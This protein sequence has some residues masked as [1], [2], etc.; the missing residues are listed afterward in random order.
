M[1][2]LGVATR[3][4]RSVVLALVVCTFALTGIGRASSSYADTPGDNSAAYDIA[5]ATVS[6]SADG[7]LTVVVAAANTDQLPADVR[8]DICFDLDNNLRTG[9]GGDEALVQR[10]TSGQLRFY[11]WVDSE[12]ERQPATGMTMSYESGVLTYSG[13]RSAFDN[14]ASFGLLVVAGG[15]RS[16]DGEDP[17]AVDWLPEAARSP[18]SS[19]GPETFSDR[20]GDIPATADIRSVKVTDTRSGIVR[21]AI[22]A[23][24]ASLLDPGVLQLWIDRDLLGESSIY[25]R[26]DV[27]ITYDGAS[28]SLYRNDD[29]EE[30]LVEVRERSLRVVPS[31]SGITVEVHRRALHDVARFGFQASFT[32]WDEDDD[33]VARDLAPDNRIW[34]YRLAN[35]APLRLVAGEIAGTPERPLAGRPFSIQLPVRR[36]DTG[37]GVAS[38]RVECAV[39][40]SGRRVRAVGSLGKGMATC[41]LVVPRDALALHGTMTVRAAGKSLTAWFAG[42][43]EFGGGLDD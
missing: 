30:G 2:T 20:T 34:T 36:S 29:V 43:V 14:V 26:T 13:P 25:D 12:L 4:P 33:A 41:K 8:I 3:S 38:G 17:G 32:K 27:L 11:R 22:G 1:T 21:F 19:P 9:D 7:R 39:F 16:M 35:P 37:R 18:Y 24:P 15:S 31:P 5:S 42:A 10:T 40:A 6:E 28:T 23:D